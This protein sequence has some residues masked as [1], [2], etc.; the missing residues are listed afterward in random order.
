M[1]EDRIE[2]VDLVAQHKRLGGAV[3]AAVAKVVASGRYINGPEVADFE[4]HLEN[5]MGVK[6]V[7]TC[8]NGTDAL[9]VALMALDLKPGDEVITSAFSFIATAEA[10]ALLGLKPVFADI[11]YATFNISPQSVREKITS[12]TKAIIPVHL[13]GQPAPM[14]AIMEIAGEHSLFVIEDNAQSLGANYK[15][16]SKTG[17]IGHIGCTSFFPSKNLGCLG[18]GGAL[19]INDSVFASKIK[20]IVNHGSD[21]K[22]YHSEVGINS[23]LDTIQAAV[24]MAKLPHLDDFNARRIDAAQFYNDALKNTKGVITPQSGDFGKHIYHQYTIRVENGLRDSLKEFLLNRGVP[25]MVYYPVPLHQQK[26]FASSGEK[27]NLPVSEKAAMEVLSLPMHT[28]LTIQ[29]L[30]HIIS[31]ITE[32][33]AQL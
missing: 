5:Y 25:S 8:G 30:K 17:T 14:D 6:H 26:V 28:E 16:G 19:I 29:Q 11:D 1:V 31:S 10:I 24:L 12:R 13:Y 15:N 21:V 22:Y 33:F 7:I 9:T 18:D 4:W 3:E 20:R 2:M 32:F 23:R 27:I